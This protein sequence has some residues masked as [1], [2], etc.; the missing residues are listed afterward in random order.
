MVHCLLDDTIKVVRFAKKNKKYL[1]NMYLNGDFETKEED[2]TIILNSGYRVR[3]VCNR[4]KIYNP[5]CDKIID[6]PYETI[7]QALNITEEIIKKK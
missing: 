6:V 5:N 1:K 7:E 2:T 4:C 3:I